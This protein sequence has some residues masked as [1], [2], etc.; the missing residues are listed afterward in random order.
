MLNDMFYFVKV[1]IG[2]GKESVALRRILIACCRVDDRT[3]VYGRW[4]L[5]F[6]ACLRCARA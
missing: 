4:M 1:A 2:V 3:A 5:C 6:A